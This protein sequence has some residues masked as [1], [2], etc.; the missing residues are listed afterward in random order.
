MYM[1]SR[2]TQMVAGSLKPEVDLKPLREVLPSFSKGLLFSLLSPSASHSFQEK[3]LGSSSLL[4]TLSVLQNFFNGKESEQRG[5][6]RKSQSVEG[7]QEFPDMALFTFSLFLICGRT[8]SSLPCPPVAQRAGCSLV[9]LR[10][11]PFLWSTG[12][13]VRVLSSCGSGAQS[14]H[15]MWDLPRPWIKPASPALRGG[16]SPTGPPGDACP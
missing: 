14:S 5:A 6:R 7:K 3:F 16:F 2:S 11:L 13:K 12:S 15:S 1:H 8:G 9:A 4:L 10:W